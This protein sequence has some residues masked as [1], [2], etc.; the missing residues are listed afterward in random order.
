MNCDA[1]G[2]SD[3]YF[4]IDGTW[5]P[6]SDETR[7]RL[8]AAIGGA[9]PGPPLWFVVQGT[10]GSLWNECRIVTEDGLDLGIVAALPTDLPLGYHRLI[11]VDGGPETTLIV[12]PGRCPDIPR[13][14]GAATQLASL[15]SERS[16]GIGDLGDLR[17]L[18]ASL[19]QAGGRTLLISPLHQ[20]APSLPQEPSPYYPSSRRHLS[21]LAI[22]IEGDPASELWCR[23]DELIDRDAAWTAKR[24]ALEALF[25]IEIGSG[26]AR[27]DFDVAMAIMSGDLVP[28]W[29]AL[30]DRYGPDWSSWPDGL[31]RPDPQALTAAFASADLTRAA[32]F[33]AWCQGLAHHQL[34]EAAATGVAIIA[35]LAVGFSPLGADAWQFQDLLALDMCL[36]APPDSFTPAGQTWGIP[37]FVPW[38]LR[39]AG[40]R[41]F[42]DTI[43]A[44]LQ[45]VQA[46]RI[47]HV[48]GLFRQ[49]WIPVDATPADGAYVQFPAD[50]L[51]A[52]VCL[53]ATRA[54]AFVIGED[55]GTVEPDA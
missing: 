21:P 47:D 38:R 8:R 54:G 35:D 27:A 26:A 42:I 12:H 13:A 22:A 6:T 7:A 45:G 25:E 19:H 10:A 49:F 29:N 18:C 39:E 24:A 15:W 20:P 37:P 43:R 50:E 28:A 1:W 14:W 33:H 46:L 34:A 16:W 9:R 48:I 53:E 44:C 2:I 52:I 3:G 55:L 23:P 51:L 36:G 30:C 40:Y 5:H 32:S 11:P 41:P 31:D 17:T 4:D